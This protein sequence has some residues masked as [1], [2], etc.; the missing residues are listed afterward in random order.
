MLPAVSNRTSGFGT[1]FLDATDS[2]SQT[3]HQ[4]NAPIPITLSYPP[5]QLQALGIAE[6]DLTLFW[7]DPTLPITATDGTV[8]VGA[9]QPVPTR[10][11]PVNQT[12]QATV[13]HFS[14]FQLSDG[15]SPSAAFI[16]SLQGFQV[17]NFTGAASYSYP[18]E[19]P[20]GPGG[21]KPSLALSYSSAAT[22]GVTG[23]RPLQQAGWVGKGWSLDTGFI[24]QNKTRISASSTVEYYSVVVNGQSYDLQR[25]AALVAQP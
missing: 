19:L 17:S 11:D 2:L 5:E 9:W 10:I 25:G 22:D 23:Q 15:S 12:A 7:Y 8:P 20:A 13:D 1:F 18:I 4:F 6:D 24:A 3:I 14:A 21:L 16:P